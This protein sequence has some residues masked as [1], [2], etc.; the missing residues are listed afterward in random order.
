MNHDLIKRVASVK[1][2]LDLQLEDLA[3][4]KEGVEVEV[5]YDTSD[6][7]DA[8]LGARIFYPPFEDSF[9]LKKFAEKRSRRLVRKDQVIAAPSSGILNSSKILFRGGYSHGSEG[10]RAQLS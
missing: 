2:N 6:V 7:H 1:K 9:N 5:Y 10:R 4:K 8:I 3:F